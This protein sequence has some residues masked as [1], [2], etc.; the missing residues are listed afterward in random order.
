MKGV[1]EIYQKIKEETGEKLFK[2]G[3][4]AKQ[5]YDASY[6]YFLEKWGNKAVE[7][8]A[9]KAKETI[10]D[11]LFV[12]CEEIECNPTTHAQAEIANFGWSIID[13]QWN[14]DWGTKLYKLKHY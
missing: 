5:N 6:R 12:I 10:T 3:L 2:L 11:Q 4:I 7:I 14:F 1:F 9:Q 8:D 13:N